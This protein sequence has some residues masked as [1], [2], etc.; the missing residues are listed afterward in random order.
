[1]RRALGEYHLEGIKTNIVFFTEILNDP[2]FLKGDFDT[3]F[4]DRLLQNRN[5]EPQ[6]SVL[7]RDL[8]VLAAALFHSESS[9]PLTAAPKQME[10]LWKLAGRQ[11]SLRTQ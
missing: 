7:E 8:S 1:M 3:G 2:D 4:I 6:I 11:R 10:S 5:G 9:A